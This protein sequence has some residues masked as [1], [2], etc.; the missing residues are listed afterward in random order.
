MTLEIQSQMGKRGDG[1]AKIDCQNNHGNGR[2]LDLK[3]FTNSTLNGNIF[4][5]CAKI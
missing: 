2:T 4:C 5:K 3:Y 1:S